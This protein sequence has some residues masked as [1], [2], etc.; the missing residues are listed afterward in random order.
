MIFIITIFLF[1]VVVVDGI[2][3]TIMILVVVITIISTRYD[4]LCKTDIY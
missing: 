2:T 1:F 3:N 4:I